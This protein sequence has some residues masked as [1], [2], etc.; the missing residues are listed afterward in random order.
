MPQPLWRGVAVAL[1]TMF[2]NQGGVDAAAT[3]AHARRLVDLGIRAI[4]VAGSTGEADSL[5]DGE[6]C[7]L[8]AA[9]RR[10]CPGVPLV[11]GG[12]GPWLAPVAARCA[13][14]LSA[15][16]DAV[17][18][19][20]PR[21]C[22]DVPAFFTGLA[23]QV[24]AQRLYAYHF[25]G[26]AG[27]EV[28]LDGLDKLAVAGL[29]DSTGSPERLAAELAGWDRDTY[30]GNAMLASTGGAWGATGAILAVAN[31]QPELAVAAF[32]GDAMAQRNLLA[33]HLAAKSR[34]PYGL[35]EIVAE[36]FGTS[37]VARA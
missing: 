19:A 5:T 7:A 31:A 29:K 21:R 24:G 9:V 37:T 20:P 13:A 14:V 11:A 22:L 4:L 18:V 16:A 15:G 12:S 8:V 33:A 32:G 26:V 6:R 27:A 17:L 1:V 30:V 2:D 23:G 28:P 34:F 10:E 3:A 36:R 25:P 35:K